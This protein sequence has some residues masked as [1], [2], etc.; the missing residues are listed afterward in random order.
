[1]RAKV[2]GGT[3]AASGQARTSAFNLGNFSGFR[4]RIFRPFILVLYLIS[5]TLIINHS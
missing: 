1:M 3:N 2:K 4:D 5:F